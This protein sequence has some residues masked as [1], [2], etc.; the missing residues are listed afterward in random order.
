MDLGLDFHRIFIH[1]TISY[2]Y[3]INN[4]IITQY[5]EE[6]INSIYLGCVIA[7]IF[8]FMIAAQYL[9]HSPLHLF[10]S[11]ILFG[12][13]HIVLLICSNGISCTVCITLA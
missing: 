12:S 9:S 2:N 4:T 3:S 7:V 13:E 6:D 5:M 10:I 8:E 1:E 11:F